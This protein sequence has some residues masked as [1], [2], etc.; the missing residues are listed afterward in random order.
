MALITKWT[1]V[2]VAVQ[3][4]LATAK[5]ITA[6][7]KA[8]PGV[9]SSTAHGYANGDY[10]LLAIQGMSQLNN[11]VMRVSAVAT[12]SFSLEGEDTTLYDT[13]ATGT[14]QKITYGTTMATVTGLSSSGGDFDFVDTTTIHDSVKTQIPGLASPASYNLDNFWDV[15]DAALIALKRA[16]DNQATLAMRF[17]FAN[18]QTVTFMGYV[19]ATLLPGG[20]AQQLVTTP[21]VLTM[22]GRPT[23][24]ATA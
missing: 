5:T 13:F 11:R 14:A 12:D 19:G 9:V 18:G 15:S 23:V 17:R 24:F 8:S 21:V 16:S 20:T 7:T 6:I 1:N 10:I 22:F 3:S 4:A 2:Q